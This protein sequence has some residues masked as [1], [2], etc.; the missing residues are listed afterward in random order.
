[1]NTQLNLARKWRSKDFSQIIGQDLLV[2][3]LKNSL[4]LSHY[5]PVYLFAGQRG[6]GKTTTARVFAA[7]VNCEQLS[8]FQKDPKNISLPCLACT[9]CLAMKEGKHPDF[10]EID[11]ASHTGVDN[12]RQI[13]DASS[14]LPLMGRKKIYLIDEAHMLSKAAF[15]AFL[16]LLE[17][18]PVSVLFILATTD[19]QKIIE[20][21][22]SRCFQ[23]YFKPVET[24]CLI[25][26]LKNMCEHESIAI[27]QDA[28]HMIVKETDGSV[29]DA[30]NLLEQVRFSTHKVNKN[31]VLA[32]LGHLDDAR[33]LEL[34]TLILKGNARPLLD[35][36][37][38][39]KISNYSADFIWSKLLEITRAALW[40]KY[41]VEPDYA[42]D[43]SN[44]LSS[45]I[46]N[47]TWERIHT[48]MATFYEHESVFLKTAAQHALIEM[49]LLKLCIKNQNNEDSGLPSL[50]SAPAQAV[51]TI[52]NDK[53][54]ENDDE[55]QDDVIDEVKS[56]NPWDRFVKEV[57]L[58]NDPLII[59]VFKQGTVI[60]WD[61][62]TG[63]LEVEFAKDFVFFS[64]WLETSKTSWLPFLQAAYG[65]QVQLVP[66]FTGTK[67]DI[68][69][70]L[71]I[72]QQETQTD[73]KSKSVARIVTPPVAVEPKKV[74][75]AAQARPAFASFAQK[76]RPMPVKRKEILLDISDKQKWKIAHL[77]L[78]YFPG[79]ISEIS[80]NPYE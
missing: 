47:Y 13:I 43:Y 66:L 68:V 22:R 58:I 79:T 12:V 65:K 44:E 49:L 54:E 55:D 20:T 63:K 19:T 52:D 42:L 53:Q 72:E 2:R 23:L 35:F 62:S 7:A 74:Q 5:F 77:L 18:P 64:D 27:D 26:Y 16:K 46:V 61:E 4:Y 14:F 41:K 1:M 67:K 31:A 51:H 78:E 39:N 10:I 8:A 56:S 11:A 9:S 75:P 32:V 40:L 69:L 60:T 37:H 59:S 3:M 76:K 6:C 73:E 33:M 29:R 36:I 70:S 38:L 50:A 17:E 25:D 21:V 34:F 45:I 48:V 28:L 71:N 30:I 80:E 57:E 24:K 15:N